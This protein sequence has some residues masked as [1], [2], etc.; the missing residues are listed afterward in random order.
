MIEVLKSIALVD[1]ISKSVDLGV[2]MVRNLIV[3]KHPDNHRAALTGGT[4]DGYKCYVVLQCFL[5]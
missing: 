4:A 2:L 3:L 5:W 1:C